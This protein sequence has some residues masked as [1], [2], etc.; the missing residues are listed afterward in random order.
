MEILRFIT[1][2]GM[3]FLLP[4]LIAFIFF[5]KDF[6]KAS[7]LMLL[8]NLVDLDHLLAN[9]IF[10]SN[11]CSIGFHFLH[12][13]FAIAFYFILLFIPKTRIIGIGLVLHILTDFIDCL[14]I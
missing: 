4:V 5:R 11:R 7:V 3:H 13:Y 12:S 1:H 9:P 8:A 2:Y 10:D 14:W 6:W